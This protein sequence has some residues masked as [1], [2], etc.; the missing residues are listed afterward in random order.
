MPHTIVGTRFCAYDHDINVN[1][2]NFRIA[3]P[4]LN[5][6]LPVGASFDGLNLIFL[7]NPL[8]TQQVTNFSY[9]TIVIP[10]IRWPTV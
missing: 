6:Q 3:N 10:S 4:E 2:L 9:Y 7:Q 8:F 1:G 5:S